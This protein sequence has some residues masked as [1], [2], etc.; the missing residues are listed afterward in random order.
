MFLMPVTSGVMPQK[1][2]WALV[3]LC[4]QRVTTDTR[5]VVFISLAL[6]QSSTGSFS[7]VRSIISSCGPSECKYLGRTALFVQHHVCLWIWI[8][9][10][11]GLPSEKPV[12]EDSRCAKYHKATAHDR[13][14][15]MGITIMRMIASATAM[16]AN[17]LQTLARRRP[18]SFRLSNAS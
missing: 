17:N 12:S 5:L 13:M 18:A 9:L 8:W 2:P 7:G 14:V 3:I 6:K 1:P 11:F 15:T 4:A 10:W 16:S